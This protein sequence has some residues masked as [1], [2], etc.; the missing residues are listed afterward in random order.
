MVGVV[1]VVVGMIVGVVAINSDII[2]SIIVGLLMSVSQR[3]SSLV[4][5]DGPPR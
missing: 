4:S 1:A 5:R 2:M 3:R